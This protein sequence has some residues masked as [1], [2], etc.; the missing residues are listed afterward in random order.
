MAFKKIV[1]NADHL[2]LIKNIKFEPFVFE[3]TENQNGRFGW[4]IDQYSLFG[5]TY[6]MEDIAI[7]L[8]KWDKFIPGTE[9]DPL[10]RRYPK[11]LEDYW[12]ELY[13]YIFNN[14]E[15][16]IDLVLQYS[17]NGGLTVGTYKLN[18]QGQ[19]TKVD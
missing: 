2:T 17:S 3:S 8:D 5:G 15:Y 7:A 12:W 13:Q 18:G 14:M 4:G 11:E 1:L 19:W 16:I 6:V 10:G 9:E